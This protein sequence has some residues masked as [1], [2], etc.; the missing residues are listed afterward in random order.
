MRDETP[1]KPRSKPRSHAPE[2]ACQVR[3]FPLCEDEVRLCANAVTNLPQ[4]VEQPFINS[5]AKA[6]Q[7]RIFTAI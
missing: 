7:S 4:P 1:D 2:M 3:P 6:A 5:D